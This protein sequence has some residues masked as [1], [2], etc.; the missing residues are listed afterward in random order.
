VKTV[1]APDWP[2]LSAYHGAWL[3]LDGAYS[4]TLETEVQGI[5]RDFQH[6]WIWRGT[7]LEY[8]P[9]GYRHGPLLVPLSK[10]LLAHFISTWAPE[11]SGLLLMSQALGQQLVG[12]LQQLHQVLA[13]D[14][15]PLTFS[16]TA[17]RQLE[18]FCEALTP[19]RLA[20]LLGPIQCLIWNAGHEQGGQ[21]LRVDTFEAPAPGQYLRLTPTE[22]EALDQ[23]SHAWFLRNS[24]RLLAQRNPS[25]A[26]SEHRNEFHRQ[27]QVFAREAK[28]FGLDLERD[29]RHYMTLRLNY[30]Q[31]PF[32]ND[33]QLNALLTQFDMPGRQR[34]QA[35]EDRLRQLVPSA[36]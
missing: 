18:E 25:L 1:D 36:E 30:P 14:G 15:M 3:C 26:L 17:F 11:Q 22:E 33:P 31:A 35:M 2:S 7:S 9:P 23:A 19:E 16:L 32:K 28:K 10:L 4:D 6:Q 13:A 21:W 29:A 20:Q 12:H 8:Q 27:L 34:V 24:A 5:A